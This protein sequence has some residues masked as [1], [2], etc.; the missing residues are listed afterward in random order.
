MLYKRGLRMRIECMYDRLG[1]VRP[2]FGFGGQE[3][4]E[5]FL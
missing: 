3:K 2:G 5:Y 4:G 1:S